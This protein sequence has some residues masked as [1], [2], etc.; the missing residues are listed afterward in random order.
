VPKLRTECSPIRKVKPLMSLEPLKMIYYA[1]FHSIMNY[2]IILG[3]IPHVVI[4][5]LGYK[6]G[7]SELY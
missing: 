1:Y 2:G 5:F 7:L 3:K 4:P 6:R